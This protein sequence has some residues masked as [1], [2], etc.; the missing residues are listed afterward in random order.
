MKEKE[1]SIEEEI[2]EEEKELEVI[3][4]KT[5]LVREEGE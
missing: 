1:E 4:D 3:N 2:Q 5:E